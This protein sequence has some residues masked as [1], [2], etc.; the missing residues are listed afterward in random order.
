MAANDPWGTY[1]LGQVTVLIWHLRPKKLVLWRFLQFDT[2]SAEPITT[3]YIV[4]PIV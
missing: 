2:F 3:K 4:K 1:Q